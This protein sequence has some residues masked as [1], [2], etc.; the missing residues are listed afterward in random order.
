M[1]DAGDAV[2]ADHGTDDAVLAAHDDILAAH[3]AVFVLLGAAYFLEILTCR[4]GE[5]P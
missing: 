2:L 3:E 5:D 1:H 4:C